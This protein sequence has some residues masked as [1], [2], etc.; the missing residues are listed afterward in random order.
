MADRRLSPAELKARLQ[1]NLAVQPAKPIAVPAPAP[2]PV[3]PTP[4]P[5]PAPVSGP[6]PVAVPDVAPSPVGV[7]TRDSPITRNPRPVMAPVTAPVHVDAVLTLANRGGNELRPPVD[8]EPR[9]ILSSIPMSLAAA[10]A[11]TSTKRTIE[12]VLHRADR[13]AVLRGY[14]IPIDLHRQAERTKVAISAERGTSVF[15]DELLQSSID[16]IPSDL[17]RIASDLA[18]TR[19]TQPSVAPSTRVLQATIRQDQDLRLRTLRIDLEEIGGATIRLE[20]IWT[21]LIRRVINN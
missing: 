15:W 20:E 18:T 5:A 16:A 14:R 17:T 11:T 9:P 4:V 2:A 19:R 12:S 6:G 10:P 8:P 1:A 13:G 7:L 3:A 21:W